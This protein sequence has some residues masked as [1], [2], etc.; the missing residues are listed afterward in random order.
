MPRTKQKPR[1]STYWWNEEISDLRRE[2]IRHNRRVAQCKGNTTRRMEA[3]REYR[4]A[5]KSLRTAIQRSKAAAWK[6][7]L[8]TLKEDPWGRPYKIVLNK[9]RPA[10]PPLTETLEPEFVKDVVATL[11]PTRNDRDEFHPD[12]PSQ[13]QEWTEDMEIGMGELMRAI[14]RGLKGNTTPGPDGIQKRVWVLASQKLAEHIRQIFNSCLKREIF[15]PIWRKAKLVLLRKDGKDA[16]LPSTYRPICL[17]DEIGKLYER[18]IANRIVQHLTHVGPNISSAQYGFRENLSTVDAINHVRALTE[19]ET[20]QGRV[21]LVISLDISNAFNSLPWERI[22]EAL[23]WH[24]V[25]EHLRN[26]IGEYLRERWVTYTDQTG[27]TCEVE[28]RCGVPQG[29]VLGPLLWNVGYNTVLNTAMP[30]QM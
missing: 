23:Q 19:E 6:E 5:R 1:R 16:S 27:T 22:K 24:G 21:V 11:F 7:L 30:P 15:P 2:A 12:P 4:E 3:M 25:D 10:A 8:Q 17:L 29:S 20:S 26:V 18:I 9:L 14:K 13:D 28:L